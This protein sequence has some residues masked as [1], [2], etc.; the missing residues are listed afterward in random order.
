MNTISS[1]IYFEPHFVDLPV[2]EHC[3]PKVS[4]VSKKGMIIEGAVSP[5]LLGVNIKATSQ[6]PEGQVIEYYGTTNS[7]GKYR[8][9]PVDEVDF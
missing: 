9:G 1:L 5:A 6:T 4:F 2:N 8:I 3:F 7:D